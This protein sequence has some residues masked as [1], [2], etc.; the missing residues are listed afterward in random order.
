MVT[1]ALFILAF[2]QF[3][4]STIRDCSRVVLYHISSTGVVTNSENVTIDYF[5]DNGIIKNADYVTVGYDLGTRIEDARHV[6]IGYFNGYS[7]MNKDHVK[8]GYIENNGTV[9]DANGV[10]LGSG[11]NIQ[12]D[13]TAIL[14]FFRGIL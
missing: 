13:Y 7:V 9:R 3:T 10:C 6:T 4:P 14:F 2:F 12:K 1:L 8:I 11:P 5:D